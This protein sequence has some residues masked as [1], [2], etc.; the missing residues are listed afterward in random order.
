M[1]DEIL[2]FRVSEEA[3]LNSVADNLVA[4]VVAKYFLDVTLW[5]G[6]HYPIKLRRWMA[7]LDLVDEKMEELLMVMEQK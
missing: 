3:T 6:N 7:I 4:L 2:G 1:Y 5:N